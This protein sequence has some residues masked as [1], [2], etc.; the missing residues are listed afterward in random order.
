MSTFSELLYIFECFDD[1]WSVCILGQERFY[2]CRLLIFQNW[3]RD[4]C[5]AQSKNPKD[6][7]CDSIPMSNSL[8]KYCKNPACLF[9]LI[10]VAFTCCR[11]HYLQV[12]SAAAMLRRTPR[13]HE[14]PA[15]SSERSLRSLEEQYVSKS[16]GQFCPYLP[17]RTDIDAYQK[18]SPPMRV[19]WRK[20]RKQVGRRGRK[21]GSRRKLKCRHRYR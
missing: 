14:P 17:F 11:Y 12:S 19:P 2:K 4:H 6:A 16:E 21:L 3:E 10:L 15:M 7:G 18:M 9:L 8:Q 20:L 5:S 13:L 1:L